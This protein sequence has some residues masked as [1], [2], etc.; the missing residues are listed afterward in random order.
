MYKFYSVIKS[1]VTN[2]QFSQRFS[3][4][5]IK[6]EQSVE[7]A[8]GAGSQSKPRVKFEDQVAAD[9]V[10]KKNYT[11]KELWDMW[12]KDCRIQFVNEETQ[13]ITKKQFFNFILD[14]GYPESKMN[15]IELYYSYCNEDED[16][17]WKESIRE[18]SQSPEPKEKSLSRSQSTTSKD[19]YKNKKKSAKSSSKLND[20]QQFTNLNR[21]YIVERKR[22][23]NE[24]I[25]IKQFLYNY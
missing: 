2:K 3:N 18:K 11:I 13:E 14:L 8:T 4:F 7:K 20:S 1:H 5:L 22:K 24:N 10:P 15:E 16:I 21:S 9:A 6:M 23:I 25:S 12:M 19:F 17:E